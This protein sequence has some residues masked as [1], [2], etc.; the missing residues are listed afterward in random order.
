MHDPFKINRM[1]YD[2]Q[3]E[4]HLHQFKRSGMKSHM[5]FCARQMS[6]DCFDVLFW[7]WAAG[8]ITK[9]DEDG[10]A[11]TTRKSKEG[12]IYRW[13]MTP[14]PSPISGLLIYGLAVLVAFVAISMIL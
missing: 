8:S 10:N 9:Y 12:P 5:A 3:I 1:S 14:L 2:E 13:L 11:I 7:E 4:E 6:G